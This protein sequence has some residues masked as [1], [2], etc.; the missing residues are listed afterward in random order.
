MRSLPGKGSQ[1]QTVIEILVITW[2]HEKR[3]WT[4]FRNN[5]TLV[6]GVLYLRLRKLEG[7]INGTE[8]AV[9]WSVWVAYNN[10]FKYL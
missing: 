1:K 8:I 5:S 2:D 4:I 10:E 7:N 9:S 6:Q 3:D